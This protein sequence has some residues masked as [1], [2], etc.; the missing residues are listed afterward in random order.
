MWRC[1]TSNR[2][3]T[4][5]ASW[6]KR[7]MD[8]LKTCARIAPVLFRGRRTR[9]RALALFALA[10]VLIQFVLI[11]IQ[12]SPYRVIPHC[13]ETTDERNRIRIIKKDGLLYKRLINSKGNFSDKLVMSNGQTFAV[14]I[15]SRN[16]DKIVVR[17]KGMHAQKLWKLSKHRPKDAMEPKRAFS[18]Q[19][20]ETNTTA[21]VV[22]RKLG[23]VQRNVSSHYQQQNSWKK[24]ANNKTFSHQKEKT[25]VANITT[26][27]V[28]KE[29]FKIKKNS[30]SYLQEQTIRR[31]RSDVCPNSTLYTINQLKVPYGICQPHRPTQA[32]C[33]LARQLYNENTVKRY[34]KVT[35]GTGDICHIEADRKGKVKKGSII[36]RCRNTICSDVNKFVNR[37][38]VKIFDSQFGET[39]TVKKFE[40]VEK[41]EKGLAVIIKNTTKNK[42]YFVFVLCRKTKSEW[43][44]QLLPIDPRLTIHEADSQRDPR[45]VNVNIILIDSVARAHFYRSL[46][47]TVKTFQSWVDQPSNAPA[48]VLDFELFQAVY[49][50]T[51]ENTQALFAGTFINPNSSGAVEMGVLFGH[52]KKAGY[53][54]TWQEDLCYKGVWGLRRDL[55]AR[56]WGEM[57]KLSKKAQIDSTGR[58]KYSGIFCVCEIVSMLFF[59]LI[60]NVIYYSVWFFFFIFVADPSHK[61]SVL[62][63]RLYRQIIKC[64]KS[65]SGLLVER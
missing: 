10:V 42:F 20:E 47:R 3:V 37:F 53:Q 18:Y 2:F 19:K 14:Q 31:K 64:F 60:H 11:H 56:N 35:Q 7:E 61:S 21:R 52:Y 48:T 27:N 8:S 58:T 22:E 15:L 16:E 49:G 38:R 23:N 17:L 32:A 4:E 57:Q 45:A 51:N 29:T 59:M 54:T 62:K 50:H 44:S 65:H 12:R 55:K 46:P 13:P 26:Q 30:S 63:G 39:K 28:N 36:V 5:T 9:F 6:F 41:L 1:L 24:G 34:C 40:T 43:L 33:K 25:S